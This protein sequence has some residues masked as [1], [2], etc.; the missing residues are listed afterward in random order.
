M[1]IQNSLHDQ[2]EGRYSNRAVELI[3]YVAN[4]DIME[5]VLKLELKLINQFSDAFP[6]LK[7]K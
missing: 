6:L 4:E 5:P 3:K 7:N 1:S 2:S